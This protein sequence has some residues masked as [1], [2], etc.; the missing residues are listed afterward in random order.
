MR[1][2]LIS[3]MPWQDVSNRGMDLIAYALA[4]IGADV[5]VLKFPTYVSHLIGAQTRR[6]LRGVRH[7]VNL[8]GRIRSST[9][10]SLGLPYGERYFWWIKWRPIFNALRKMTCL[11]LP[12]V[13]I[14]SYEIIVVESGKPVFFAGTLEKISPPSR[15][16]VIY[17]QS[18]P[19]ELGLSRNP[20]FIEEERRMLAVAD[21][22]LMVNERIQNA[23][24]A[25]YP[26]YAHKFVVWENGFNVS[27]KPYTIAGGE[28]PTAVYFGL[29]PID[30]KVVTT[31]ARAL[32]AVMFHIIGPVV[33]RIT[34]RRIMRRCPNIVFHGFMPQ[35][36]ALPLIANASVAIV[37]YRPSPRLEFAGLTSKLLLFM[38]YGLPIVALSRQEAKS[39]SN[40]G[41]D[42][43]R[44]VED[45][46]DRVRYYTEQ[47]IHKVYNISLSRY[48]RDNRVQ[49]LLRILKNRGLLFKKCDNRIKKHKEDYETGEAY[50]H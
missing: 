45:F 30:L 5:H 39:L 37:P 25:K 10:I 9:V 20:R 19:I 40:V 32:P 44:K 28:R 41:V 47:K 31:A 43:C 23:Y 21:L 35:E 15:P 27:A 24:K 42:V 12:T 50:E 48:N 17:R 46:I 22:V 38:Y 16:V 49:E 6:L 1:C 14:S 11:T 34:A 26:Q 4:S 29:F 33:S 3:F 36:R 18:D 2:L 13:D 8:S 7:P